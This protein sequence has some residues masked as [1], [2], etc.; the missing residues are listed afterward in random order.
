MHRMTRSSSVRGS[1][2]HLWSGNAPK[3]RCDKALVGHEQLKQEVAAAEPV[4]AEVPMQESSMEVLFLRA[5]VAQLEA[6]SPRVH[7]RG[8]EFAKR[9]TGNS[10]GH[11][12]DESTR[13]SLFVG[14]EAVGVARCPRCS[15]YGISQFVDG[16]DFQRRLCHEQFAAAVFGGA[17]GALIGAWR[18]AGY[19]LRGTRPIQVLG[20]SEPSSRLVRMWS[21]ATVMTHH[22]WGPSFQRLPQHTT[23]AGWVSKCRMTAR[24]CAV[25]VRSTDTRLR[26]NRRRVH[27]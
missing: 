8:R 26:S 6:S 11:F 18:E 24:G 10:R 16:T 20:G 7:R 19:G 23:I 12:T 22:V 13:S 21:R 2:L 14:G 15:R 9:K 25:D 27:C 5:K 17:H 4:P 3:R 1:E